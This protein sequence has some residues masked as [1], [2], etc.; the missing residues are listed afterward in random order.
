MSHTPKYLNGT[1][2]QQVVCAWPHLF[3]ARQFQGKGDP[4]FDVSI[5]MTAEQKESIRQNIENLA[6]EAFPNGEYNRTGAIEIQ[7]VAPPPA[8]QWPYVMTQAK[9]NSPK[10][11]ELFPTHWIMSAKAYEDNPPQVLIPDV[12]NP[13]TYIPMPETQRPQF[14][15]DGALCYAGIDFA[16]YEQGPN[17]GVRAQLN[18]IVFYGAGEKVAIGARPD[19]NQ[20]MTGITVQMQVPAGMQ[21]V[22]QQGGMPTQGVVNTGMPAPIGQQGLQQQPV[23][24]QVVQQG[25]QQQPVQN[26]G[27]VQ[28]P[29]IQT[30]GVAQ[31]MQ[32]HQPVQQ[33]VQQGNQVVGGQPVP[34][35]DFTQQ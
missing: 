20:V 23:Q 7:G 31:P 8:F 11:A 33:G 9:I 6:I 15:F 18:F 32:Q 27:T 4:R 24:Q 21:Q 3:Q 29:V 2:L 30:T 19:A 25:V 13:G 34:Q 35:V 14:V 1:V 28:Q 22:G 16:S 5:I 17:V 12:N 26:A 10:L